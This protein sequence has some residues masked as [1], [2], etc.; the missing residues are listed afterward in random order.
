MH[1]EAPVQQLLKIVPS[2]RLV[3]LH[4]GASTALKLL[5]PDLLVGSNTLHDSNNSSILQ[6]IATTQLLCFRSGVGRH[7]HR[8]SG[9]YN[10]EPTTCSGLSSVPT[11]TTTCNWFFP[12]WGGN[13]TQCSAR[14][15]YCLRCMNTIIRQPHERGCLRKLMGA[16]APCCSPVLQVVMPVC[17]GLLWQEDSQAQR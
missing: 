1:T 6:H 11:S 15:H 14:L 5:S 9:V 7:I 10:A 8:K 17:T 2:L 4:A 16:P 3:C 12:T 13:L